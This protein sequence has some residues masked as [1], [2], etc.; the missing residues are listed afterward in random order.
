MAFSLAKLSACERPYE[1]LKVLGSREL[2]NEE[3]LAIILQSGQKGQSSLDLASKI[4]AH[5]MVGHSMR[6]LS[7]LEVNDLLEIKGIGLAK[8]ARI[9]ASLE[10]GKR[11]AQPTNESSD[12]QL[13]NPENVFKFILPFLDLQL[14][15]IYALLLD[16]HLRLLHLK[17]IGQGHLTEAQFNSKDLLRAA[18]RYNAKSVILVH[19]HPSGKVQAS[20]VDCLTTKKMASLLADYSVDLLDHVIVTD[21]LYLSLYRER[22][23]LFV[24]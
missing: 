24:A 6:Q 17:L 3:L 19:N 4:L 7:N 13:K 9:L 21:S 18:L 14:E 22:S 5:D 2:S 15:K 1:K 12:M 10:L 23:D 8:A 11:L 16:C 20:E